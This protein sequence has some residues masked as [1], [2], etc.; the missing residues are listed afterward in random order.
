VRTTLAEKRK[1][2]R[3]IFTVLNE[4]HR[5]LPVDISKKTGIDRRITGL[6]LKEAYEKGHI[7]GPQVRKRSYKNFAEYVCLVSCEDALELFEECVRKGNTIY[8]AIMNGFSNFLIISENRIDVEGNIIVEGP[9]SDYHISFAPNHSWDT[10]VEIMR[11]KV[12]D[13]DLKDYEPQGI[14]KNH[15]DETI[16]W[17][18]ENE[19][20]FEYFKY[21]L[22]KPITPLIKKHEMNGEK[23][24]NWLDRL[25]QYCTIVTG[26]YPK[27]ISAY[28][29][30]VLMFETDYEDFIIDLFSQLPTT[31]WSFKIANKLLLY[32]WVDRGSM[33]SIDYR[34]PDISKLHIH[35]LSRLLL[36]KGIIRS[37][38]HAIV[39][40]Y[41]R[42]DLDI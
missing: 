39:E 40:C 12:E 19:L 11:K 35:Q 31:S 9:R 18:K 33:R 7:V 30:Y 4:Y 17:D 22:R 28:D 3:I 2:Y 25:S 14:I 29:P 21:D 10:A 38:A 15:W 1:Q 32:V 23:I 27:T 36:K 16:A 20:L 42:E 8:H 26:Y 37:K 41:W 5:I 24:E 6:R 13:F 34:V